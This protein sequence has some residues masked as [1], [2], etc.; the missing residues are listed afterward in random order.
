MVSHRCIDGWLVNSG[1]G[2]LVGYVECSLPAIWEN[3][4]DGVAL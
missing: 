3:K 4:E 1:L 2:L